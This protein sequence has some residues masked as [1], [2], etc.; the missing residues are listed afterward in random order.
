MIGLLLYSLGD[1]FTHS[2]YGVFVLL[3]ATSTITIATLS[4][5]S[6]SSEYHMDCY[7][8]RE[9]RTCPNCSVLMKC[10]YCSLCGGTESKLEDNSSKRLYEDF[11]INYTL[12]MSEE[13]LLEPSQDNFHHNYRDVGSVGSINDDVNR[14]A[15]NIP[16]KTAS[17]T[18]ATPFQCPECGADGAQ[19][20]FCTMCGTN[21]AQPLST[22]SCLAHTTEQ[23]TCCGRTWHGNFCA[24]CGKQRTSLSAPNTLD[25]YAS[26][27]DTPTHKKHRMMPCLTCCATYARECG[28]KVKAKAITARKWVSSAFVIH[29]SQL[30]VALSSLWKFLSKLNLLTFFI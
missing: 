7:L 17:Q 29:D 28:R 8:V 2:D 19:R 20:T 3:S 26:T 21:L 24:C 18:H 14:I 4:F 16:D 30:K 22:T 6:S 15:L 25:K 27:Q 13:T 23:W 10:T 11:I 5:M 9:K 12:S 1:L